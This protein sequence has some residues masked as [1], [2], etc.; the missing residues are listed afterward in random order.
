MAHT[1]ITYYINKKENKESDSRN[2]TRNQPNFK[3]SITIPPNIS[4]IFEI[5]TEDLLIISANI[6]KN[7]ELSL[8]VKSDVEDSFAPLLS[9][10]L[11]KEFHPYRL[12]KK[13]K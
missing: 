12:E 8:K 9:E 7:E 10:Y 11:A 3:W 4:F 13:S 6:Y 2:F 5:S 1:N